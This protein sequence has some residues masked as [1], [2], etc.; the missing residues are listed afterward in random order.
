MSDD[1]KTDGF[2]RDLS[3][4]SYRHGIAIGGDPVVFVM[5]P[6]D[7]QLS[8]SLD[9]DSR[10]SF[11]ASQRAGESETVTDHGNLRSL[12]D[13]EAE[14]LGFP[15]PAADDDLAAAARKVLDGLNRRIDEA[16]ADAAP[17]FDGIVEL[18]SALSKR[19]NGA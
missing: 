5:G 17:V 11:D 7:Y 19:E 1:T 8:Y 14:A 3:D 6:E 9:G 2:L 12:P 16:P 4:L 15:N 13:E 18:S 10:L